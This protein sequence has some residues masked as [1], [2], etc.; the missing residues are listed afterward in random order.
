M[1]FQD[2]NTPAQGINFT[3]CPCETFDHGCCSDGVSVAGGPNKENCPGCAESEFG[4]C[5]DNFT[6]ANGPDMLGRI[7][8]P[9][10]WFV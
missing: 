1:N 5:P 6:P 9:R 3:G 8:I 10:I 4:C 2:L 7:S